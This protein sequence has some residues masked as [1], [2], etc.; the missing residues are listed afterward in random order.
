VTP[1]RYG[2]DVGIVGGGLLGL[3]VAYRLV[4]AGRA[5]TVYERDGVLGGLAATTDLDGIPVDR[6]YHVTLPTD[7]RIIGLAGELGL[8]EDRFRFRRIGSGFYHEGRLASM[9]TARE[10]LTFPGL[11]VSDRLRLAAFGVSCAL[12]RDG[13]RLEDVPLEDWL[14]RVSGD[15][16]WERVWRPL[17]DSKF[18]GRFD[19]LP[20]TY[21]WARMRRTG[22]TRDRRGQEVYGWL[23]GGYQALID[24]LAAAITERGGRILTS[25]PVRSI[26][27]QNGR[28][29]GVL[30]EDGLREHDTIVTTQLRPALDPLLSDELRA[31]LGPDRNRYLGVVCLVARLPRSVSPYYALNITDRRVPLTSIVETTHV[32]DPEQVGGTLLYVPRYVDPSSPELDRP[33]AEIRREYLG[34]VQTIFPAFRPDD[35]LASQVARARVA[36]PVHPMSAGPRVAPLFPVPGLA[37]ASS[38]RIYPD[39]VNGQAIVGVADDVARAVLANTSHVERQ[40]EA[41]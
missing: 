28:P 2:S 25:T 17:L 10:L 23:S 39:L 16:L 18:D 24:R 34:H 13:D 40:V 26:P 15:R 14:R 19:D 9:S 1:D 29:I 33:S 27:S 6:Y 35:V 37:V 36:E 8:G 12:L 21:M 22:G 32:V 31:A 20:A 30:T 4:C 7:D 41:A 38:A 11:A 3:T 5:V